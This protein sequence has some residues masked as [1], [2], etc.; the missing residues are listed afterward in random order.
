MQGRRLRG[1][2]RVVHR[3]VQEIAGAVAGEH[4]SGAIGAVSGRSEP[5]NQQVRVGISES[6]DRLAPVFPVEEGAALLASH[7]FAVTHQPRAF[8]A[9]HNLFVNLKQRVQVEILCAQKWN[10]S[11]C[12]ARASIL[13]ARA[14][15][16]ELTW[17]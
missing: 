10:E 1:E 8:A 3:S 11:K 7:G 2:A 5:Q 12:F 17:G 4:P 13:T 14:L 6:R 9:G 15:A 16:G